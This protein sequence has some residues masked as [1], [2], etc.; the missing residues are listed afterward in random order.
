MYSYIMYTLALKWVLC[1]Y[2]GAE[3]SNMWVLEAS[4]PASLGRGVRGQPLFH[5]I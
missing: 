5:A 4:G 1:N 2:F 3:V